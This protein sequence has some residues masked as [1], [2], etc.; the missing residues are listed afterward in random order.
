MA[1]L[2]SD[3]VSLKADAG[4]VELTIDGETYTRTLERKNG[5]VH[6]SDDPYFEDSTVA[7]L[8]APLI[9]SNKARRAVITETNLREV[10][11]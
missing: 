6:V 3:T 8:F 9:E 11:I 1:A 7:D 4:D 5:Q 2:G 10:I